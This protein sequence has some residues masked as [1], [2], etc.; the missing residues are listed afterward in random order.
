M[1]I[2]EL[3]GAW[4]F[5]WAA[6]IAV[7]GSIFY[8]RS[9]ESVP[10]HVSIAGDF[11][12]IAAALFGVVLAGLA[13][14]A[15][16]L[17]DRYARFLRKA[18]S[19]SLDVLSQ[20]VVVAGLLVASIVATIMYRA[21]AEPVSRTFPVVEQIAFGVACFLFLWSLFASLQLVKLI[22]GLAVSNVELSLLSSDEPAPGSGPRGQTSDGR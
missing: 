3:L 20:F 12:S 14:V 8:V 9:Q 17:G 22:F 15:A 18:G 4:D 11:L 19:T 6:L 16:L 21:A 2:G 5:L 1:R 10:A 13:I 7:V